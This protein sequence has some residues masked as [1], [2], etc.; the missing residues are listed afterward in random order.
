[1]ETKEIGKILESQIARLERLKEEIE[2]GAD[3]A[4]FEGYDQDH[5]E[6]VFTE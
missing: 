1:M 6:R 5:A 3:E 4:D 2:L